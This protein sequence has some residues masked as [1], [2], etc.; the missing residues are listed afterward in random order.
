MVYYILLYFKTKV[1]SNF[2]LLWKTIVLWEQ[3]WYFGQNYGT[4][5]KTMELRFTKK[6]KHGTIPKTK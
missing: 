1:L 6:K 2:D 4:I 5:M 3:V